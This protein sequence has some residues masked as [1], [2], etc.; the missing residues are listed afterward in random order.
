MANIVYTGNKNK[1]NNSNGNSVSS[2]VS[3]SRP[4]NKLR[5]SSPNELVTRVEAGYAL[6]V[7]HPFSDKVSVYK[8]PKTVFL[9]PLHTRR[10]L[11]SLANQ[12]LKIDYD[13]T[14]GDKKEIRIGVPVFVNFKVKDDEQSIK[15]FYKERNAVITL[16]SKLSNIISMIVADCEY[17]ELKNMKVSFSD[18]MHKCSSI[19]DAVH[20]KI[21][22]DVDTVINELAA[23]GIEVDDMIIRDVD[24]PKELSD[25]IASRE[26]SAVKNDED[27]ARAQIQ[28]QVAQQQLEKEKLENQRLEDRIKHMR[29]G[30]L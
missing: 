28:V 4:E 6:V 8:G 19:P 1:M 21:E 27:L 10:T 15:N 25:A 11:I 30:G 7:E 13:S 12:A 9:T 22:P 24:L 23:L 5:Q 14:I 17:K 20:A 18:F 29:A 16:E 3:D 2:N 26:A